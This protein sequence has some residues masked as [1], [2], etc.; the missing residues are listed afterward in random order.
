MSTSTIE[1]RELIRMP[2]GIGGLDTILGGGV[3][4]GGIYMV[5]GLPGAG[6]TIL[7]HQLCFHHAARG[8]KALFVTLLAE[9]HARMISNMNGLSFFDQDQ[10]PDRLTYLSAFSDMQDGGL[11]NV[12]DLLRR[13][14]LR[15]HVTLLV[16][17]GLIADL[18]GASDKQTFKQFINDLQEVALATDCTMFLTTTAVDGDSAERTM[19]DGL[20]KLTSRTYGWQAASDIEVTKFRGSGFLNG[21]HSYKVTDDGVVVYPRLEALYASPSRADNGTSGRA[22]TG[23]DQLDT[24][25]HGGLPT[26]ST[27]MIMG[28]SGIGK[29]TMGLHFL[30]QSSA[31]E[32][33][34]MFGFYETPTRIRAKADR[35]APLQSL[36]ANGLVE[37]IWQ[38]P[39]SDLL[40]AYGARLLDSIHRRGVKRLFIDGL[41]ASQSGAIDPS[42]IGN[43]FSALANELRVLGVT[44]VY[45][46]EV[47][48][49]VSPSR[50][51]VEDAA[52]L[53]ENMILMR[54]V[55]QRT[56]LHRVISI[57]KARESDFDPSIYEFTLHHSGL[58]ISAKP[59][60]FEDI[61]S[62]TSSSANSPT[63][64]GAG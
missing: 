46:L 47:T 14:I 32:P 39:T 41:T 43:F 53:A 36:L 12:L 28:P 19:V 6:K 62:N 17:D 64:L 33:G 23:I 4:V 44:T 24:M 52:T 26:A 18:T 16:I 9:N 34:L 15:R 63:T 55:E 58:Q 54:F 7:T 30:S 27:T 11:N 29:T 59:N 8:E 5:E 51:P 10:I 57:V 61:L 42:R 22:S 38:T 40:D 1:T 20:I 13:E 3:M 35:I 45:S 25:L 56:K 2:T 49:I 37:L 50:V 31:D 60:S 21:R 48:D